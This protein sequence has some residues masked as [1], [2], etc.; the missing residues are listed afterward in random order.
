VPTPGQTEQEY[1][2]FQLMKKGVALCQHQNEFNL[3]KALEEI[4]NYTG[5]VGQSWQT[6]LLNKAIE[7]VL[8]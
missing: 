2:G 5:F 1:I 7:E 4:K 6:N 8:P 3:E